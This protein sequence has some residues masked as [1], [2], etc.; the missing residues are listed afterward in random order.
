M[1]NDIPNR[2]AD[3]MK[4][5]SRAKHPDKITV[6]DLTQA[7]GISRQTFYYYFEDMDAL[8]AFTMNRG[9]EAALRKCRKADSPESALRIYLSDYALFGRGGKKGLE[10]PHRVQHERHLLTSA[11]AFVRDCIARFAPMERAT[12]EE[13]EA[14]VSLFSCRLCAMLMD[15]A[16]APPSE[17]ATERFCAQ[18]AQM[19][20]IQ[21][22]PYRGDPDTSSKL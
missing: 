11:A 14:V 17:S 10:G 13:L 3:M 1:A 4:E 16:C 6:S 7:C 8:F 12:A 9:M 22:A 5:L 19:L 2:I 21:T 20:L 15:I 18:F